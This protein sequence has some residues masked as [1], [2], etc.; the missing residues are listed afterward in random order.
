MSFKATPFVAFFKGGNGR[1]QMGGSK[2]LTRDLKFKGGSKVVSERERISR[3]QS[4]GHEWLAKDKSALNAKYLTLANLYK[5]SQ[6]LIF[7]NP[8]VVITLCELPSLDVGLVSVIFGSLRCF[9]H[10]G[11]VRTKLRKGQGGQIMVFWLK[12]LSN[13]K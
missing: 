9:G 7:L 10:L 4:K 6:F 3:F 2:G 13:V 1:C 11:P 5:I 12:K 8:I